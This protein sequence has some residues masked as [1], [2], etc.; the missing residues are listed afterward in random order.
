MKPFSNI[1]RR[2]L[3]ATDL[4]FKSNPTWKSPEETLAIRGLL[5]RSL[6]SVYRVKKA[7]MVVSGT[8][9][10]VRPS[11]TGSGRPIIV[12]PAGTSNIK[13]FKLLAKALGKDKPRRFAHG[14]FQST[15]PELYASKVSVS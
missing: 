2:A 9:A 8:V 14:L 12:T 5:A 13:F 7:P 11:R 15:R 10:E 6:A 3:N 1:D 4:Y